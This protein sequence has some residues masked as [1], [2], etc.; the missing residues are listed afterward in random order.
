MKL[1]FSD[2]KPFQRGTKK[3]L[4]ELE[5]DILDV[6]WDSEPVTVREVCDKLNRN[7]NIAYTTVMTVMGRLAK[8]GYLEKNKCEN[9]AAYIY[10][11]VI[12]KDEFQKSIVSSVIKGLMEDYKDQVLS[13]FA[14]EVSKDE[15]DK[16]EQLVKDEV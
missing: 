16:I 7:R 6:I 12:T 15:L 10:N 5:A 8:K 1:I 2:F 14:S 9:T 11:S 13:H 4:G 3:V